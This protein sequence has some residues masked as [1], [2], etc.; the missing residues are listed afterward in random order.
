M[1]KNVYS[2]YFADAEQLLGVDG[3]FVVQPLE[4]AAV[5]VQ[6]VG[7]PSVGVALTAE[8]VADKVAYV[9]LHI[10]ICFFGFAGVHGGTPLRLACY[11]FLIYI[12]TTADK[13]RR[14]AISSPACGRRKYLL[15][16]DKML[17]CRR[18]FAFVIRKS[19]QNEVSYVSS[20]SGQIANANLCVVFCYLYLYVLVI[21]QYYF[22]NRG[23]ILSPC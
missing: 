5:D 10:A 8:F 23:T 11:R 9:Y 12:P 20:W 1:L 16:I 6:L 15:R 4:G 14:R 18:A 3:G 17:A 2:K 21:Y 7:E 19:N 22:F 13:K